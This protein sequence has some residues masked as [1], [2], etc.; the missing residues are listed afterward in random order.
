[1]VREIKNFTTLTEAHTKT[2]IMEVLE[3]VGVE[4][5]YDNILNHGMNILHKMKM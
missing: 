2:K 4:I 3:F 1:M 5:Y